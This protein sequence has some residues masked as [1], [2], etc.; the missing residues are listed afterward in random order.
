VL[1]AAGLE[2]KFRVKEFQGMSSRTSGFHRALNRLMLRVLWNCSM[3]SQ[4]QRKLH[5]LPALLCLFSDKVSGWICATSRSGTL[6]SCASGWVVD[7]CS[8]SLRWTMS[9]VTIHER[10]RALYYFQ[11]CKACKKN[12]IL[13]RTSFGQFQGGNVCFSGIHLWA[14]I[15]G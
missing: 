7:Q 13:R 2:W 3:V 15:L 10:N 11:A 8:P 4:T 14:A 9:M 5:N 1:L 6:C 12:Y